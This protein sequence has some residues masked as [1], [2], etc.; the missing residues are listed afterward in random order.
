MWSE[1]FDEL[2]C[3][4]YIL[5]AAIVALRHPNTVLYLTVTS[6]NKV[7]PYGNVSELCLQRAYPLSKSHQAALFLSA[8]GRNEYRKRVDSEELF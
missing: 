5:T 2:E 6:Q 1:S 3:W 8:L 4:F 7:S